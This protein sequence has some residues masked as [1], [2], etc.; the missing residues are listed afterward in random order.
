[1]AM[2]ATA[3]ELAGYRQEDLDTYS[4]TQ[5][6]T[7]A[8]GEFIRVAETVFTATTVTWS[9][10]ADGCTALLLPFNDITAV[11]A[12]RVNGVAVTG[13]TL[14]LDTVYRAAGFGRYCMFPPDQ[15][16]VDLTYGKTAVPDDVK[17]A[18]LEI[19]A[20][21][22]EH[23]VGWVSETIDDYTVRY[24]PEKKI[25]PAGRPWQDVA[26]DYRG[27]LIA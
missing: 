6:L 21:I 15:A 26:A 20:S 17:L 27:L 14:R 1:V 4:A 23:P 13:W 8:T 11:S 16:D 5:A 19:A 9:V 3:T 25:S 18:V 7:L 12:V 24:D 2:Y 22:Y 10:I